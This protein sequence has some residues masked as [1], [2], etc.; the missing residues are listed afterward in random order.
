[1]TISGGSALPKEEIERMVRDA[2]A[3]AEEDRQQREATEA[4][5]TAEQMIYSTEQFLSESGDKV[6]AETKE[7]VESAIADLKEAIK[8]ESETSVDDIKAKTETLSTAS[9]AMGS[10]MMAAQAQEQA[11]AE[12]A[13][14][15]AGQPEGDAS[16]EDVVDAEVVEDDEDDKDAK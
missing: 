2:E 12:G 1:M 6:P 11:N 7:P 14:G 3:H 15:E 5:N 9:Q 8:P 10:A 16:G 13:G 4:R